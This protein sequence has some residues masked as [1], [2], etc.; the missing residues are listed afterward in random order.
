[1]FLVFQ[2]HWSI[3]STGVSFEVLVISET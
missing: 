1:L 2:I 3:V